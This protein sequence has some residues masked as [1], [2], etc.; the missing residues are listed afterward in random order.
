M[1]WQ[2][3]IIHYCA[4]YTTPYTRWERGSAHIRWNISYKVSEIYRVLA[5]FTPAGSLSHCLHCLAS[6]L[7]SCSRIPQH[8]ATH[9][10]THTYKI[11][12]PSTKP[13][14]YYQFMMLVYWFWSV[15]MHHFRNFWFVVDFLNVTFKVVLIH[16][17]KAYRVKRGISST[18]S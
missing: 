3:T 8:S 2:L 6:C 5:V 16:T 18:C 9:T 7:I 13:A 11:S 17:M 10:H 4:S 1:V 15:I 14:F 12:F